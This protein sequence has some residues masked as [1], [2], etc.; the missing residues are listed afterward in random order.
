MLTVCYNKIPLS[1]LLSGLVKTV[2]EVYLRS[3]TTD[4]YTKNIGNIRKIVETCRLEVTAGCYAH[5]VLVSIT[6]WDGKRRFHLQFWVAFSAVS[7]S[8]H[9]YCMKKCER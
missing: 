5:K 7:L 1:C 9:S 4:C 8:T 2:T 6:T 3:L